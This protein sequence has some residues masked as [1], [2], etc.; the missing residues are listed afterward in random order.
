MDWKKNE[1]LANK[2][3]LRRSP[4]DLILPILITILFCYGISMIITLVFSGKGFDI[5]FFI[6]T[7][8]KIG[9][10]GVALSML[11]FMPRLFRARALKT[12][13]N[14]SEEELYTKSEL[15]YKFSNI[16]LIVFSGS[17][18]TILT[19]LLLTPLYHQAQETLTAAVILL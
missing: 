7:V 3:H 17:I 16:D 1:E 5:I 18:I 11:T 2:Y 12:E 10:L 6:E 15:R 19:S 14:L 8:Q 4:I 9:G 13:T